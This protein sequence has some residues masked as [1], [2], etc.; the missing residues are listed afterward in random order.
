MANFFSVKVNEIHKQ[1]H[2]SVSLSLD[3]GNENLNEF[4]FVP[5]QY[6]TIRANINNEDCRRS[7]SICSST[8][9]ILTI[10]VKKVYK[11]KMSTYI[12]ENL[13][14]GDLIEIQAPQGNFKL[15]EINQSN[16]RK[17]VGFAA[18]SGITPILSMIKELSINEKNSQF[19]LFFSNKTS[20]DVMFK[21]E[22]SLL[23]NN[24][25]TIKYL[26]SRENGDDEL[27]NGRIDKQKAKELLKSNMEYLNADAFYLCGPEEMIF[28]TK[29]VLE[30]L[31]VNSSKIKFE[32][33]TAPVIEENNSKKE[34]LNIEFEGDSHVT[35]IYDDE[36]VEFSLNR[37]GETILDAAMD[38]DLDVPFSCKGAV[39]CTCRA[40]VKEGSVIMDAN[41]ALSDQEVEDGYIL[42]C[43]SHPNSEKVIIDFD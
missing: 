11:G 1:T 15:E 21:E 24:N 43:Q 37:V 41:Y 10:A 20:N 14:E 31:G 32:L 25:I 2:D 9:E 26:F 28:S 27:Y 13:N 22:L 42:T 38:N 40:K 17:F 5:G 23:S 4:K 12:N 35:V 39:C 34:N 33:F 29:N 19:L 8:S 18:G 16:S 36:E 30:S 6:I 7:Y 3:V